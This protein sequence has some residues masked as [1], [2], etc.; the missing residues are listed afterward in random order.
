[1]S[2]FGL[3]FSAIFTM[4]TLVLAVGFAILD[5]RSEAIVLSFTSGAMFFLT[6]VYVIKIIKG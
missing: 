3:A 4:V 2:S 1:M 5:K 6:L